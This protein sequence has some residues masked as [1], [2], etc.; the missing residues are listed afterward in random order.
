ML[1]VNNCIIYPSSNA[2][3]LS[4]L[5]L[6]FLGSITSRCSGKW[7]RTHPPSFFGEDQRPWPGR[8]RKSSQ[9]MSTHSLLYDPDKRQETFRDA[10]SILLF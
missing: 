7:A 4:F 10:L 8:R 6:D 2:L 9:E 3:P 5:R 1:Y